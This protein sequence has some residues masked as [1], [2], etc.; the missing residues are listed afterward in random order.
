MSN[1]TTVLSEAPAGMT[2][3]LVL[4]DVPAG[5]PLTGLSYEV[6]RVWGRGDATPEEIIE[7]AALEND[8]KRLI[9]VVDDRN[10]VL[11]H[12]LNGDLR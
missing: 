1:S 2:Y 9:A 5:T 11:A 10:N 7:S 6:V 8:G 12:D 3:H 4:T